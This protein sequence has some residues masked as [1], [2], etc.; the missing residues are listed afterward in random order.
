MLDLIS[1]C[2]IS[3]RETKRIDNSYSII[4]LLPN[5]NREG[6][7][8]N[9]EEGSII[10]FKNDKIKL[11]LENVFTRNLEIY[12]RRSRINLIVDKHGYKFSFFIPRFKFPFEVNTGIKR[13]SNFNSVLSCFN[14]AEVPFFTT[15]RNFAL[16]TLTP[17]FV[18]SLM[19][20]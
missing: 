17:T 18:D 10:F 7:H 2:K 3:R 8:E 13:T 6:I 19:E 9:E 15:G 4:F 11:W 20:A 1:S 14:I 12:I 5:G 16:R